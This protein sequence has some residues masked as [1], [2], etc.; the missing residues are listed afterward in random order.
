VVTPVVPVIPSGSDPSGTYGSKPAVL[1]LVTGSVSLA[2][3]TGRVKRYYRLLWSGSTAL[4]LQEVPGAVVPVPGP[5][6]PVGQL[7]GV[8]KGQAEGLH[9]VFPS[10]PLPSS[11]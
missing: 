5:V 2:G 1:P 11:P 4:T 3:T 10:R 8:Y 9:S 7:T 6:L